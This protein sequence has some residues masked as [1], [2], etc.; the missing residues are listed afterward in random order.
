MRLTA[1]AVIEHC[2]THVVG[3]KCPRSVGFRDMPPPLSG[4]GKVLKREL[5]EP[6]WKVDQPTFPTA[7]ETA[8][9]EPSDDIG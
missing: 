5:R 3:Y 9:R 1:E 4:A 2:R 6:F 7:D 8:P